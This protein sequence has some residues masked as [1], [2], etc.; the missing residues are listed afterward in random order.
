VAINCPRCHS[1]NTD[2][3]RFCS[4]CATSLNSAIAAIP[5]YTET[6][7]SPI[8]AVTPGAVLV[9]RYKILDKIGEGGMGEVYRAIDTSLDRPVAI[10]VLPKAFAEDKERLARFEREAKLL[11]VLNHPNIAMIHGTEDSEGKRFLVLE[12]ADGETLRSRLERGPLAVEDALEICKQISE[13]LEAAHEKGIIHRD[14]K[15]GNIMIS[16]EGKVKILD[17][18]L[19]KAFLGETTNVDIEKSPTITAQMTEPGVILGTAA[20]MSPEQARGRSADRRADIWAFGCVL[21]ECLSGKRPF[22]GETVSDTLAHILKGDPAWEALPQGTPDI[23]RS[24]L[25]RCLQKDPRNRI[26]DIADARIEI[27]EAI[28]GDLISDPGLIRKHGRAWIMGVLVGGPIFAA[29]AAALITWHIRPAPISAVVHSTLKVEPGL[30]LDGLRPVSTRDRPSRIALAIAGDGSFIIYS[31]IPENPGPQTKPQLYLRRMDQ[32]NA[33]PVAGT[34]GGINPF[35]SPDDR[36]IGFWADGKLKKVAISGGV[37]ATLCDVALPF[38]ADWGPDNT[39]IFSPEQHLGLFMISDAG[40]KAEVLT[41]PDKETDQYSHRLPHFLPGGRAILFTAMGHGFDLHPRLALLDLESRKWSVLCEDAADGRYLPTGHLVF[42]RQGILMAVAFDLERLKVNGQPAPVIASVMQAL[43]QHFSSVDTAVGQYSVS[44]AGWLAYVPGGMAP[45][46]ESS[47]VRV[48]Q[49]GNVQPVANFKSS[50]SHP[51]FS[52]DGQ[53]IAYTSGGSEPFLWIYDLNRAIRS[54][55]TNDGAAIWV[56]WEPDGRSLVFGWMKSGPINLYRQLADG[57]LPMERLTTGENYQFP[58]S[59]AP[60]GATLV[61]VELHP[62][63]GGDILI[64]DMK[65]RKVT[66][67]LSSKATEGW[68]EISP[69][70]KWLAYASDESGRREVWVC[71]F[72]TPGGRWQISS[73]G[74]FEPIWSKDGKQLFYRTAAQVWVTDV[75]TEGGF[76]AGTPRLLFENRKFSNGIPIRSWD[77]WPD[78]QGFLM[79]TRDERKPEPVTE[80]ALVQNWFGEVKRLVPAGKK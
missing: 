65:S 4:N 41:V 35:L 44:R 23:I 26:H 25:Q 68:P 73:A 12:L 22:Q 3:A 30:W 11:A 7:E 10:K 33:A 52:R 76:S 67:F 48:D 79:V 18:G 42:L 51:R 29:V 2:T 59:F 31:A 71:P 20:Y 17:F 13:G 45:N 64:L 34:E 5:S 36:W 56:A 66:P 53:R 1:D 75:R 78:G 58:G 15:P 38:G 80:I 50:F 40:G 49:K 74:G 47:L 9:G 77:L 61:F 32:I 43:N 63:T 60:D 21:Y 28:A 24:L 39:I 16:P 19:A 6:L 70:G 72:P 46:S 57:S 62:D 27:A 69:D 37:P 14:L 8:H 54:R 55:L